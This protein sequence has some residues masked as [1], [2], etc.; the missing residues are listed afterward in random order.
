MKIYGISGL[1]ADKRVFQFLKLDC[2]LIPIDWIMPL[3]N[4]PIENYALRLAKVID[5][6]EEFGI[7]G[8]S[9]GGLIAVELSKKLNPTL[10][11]LISSA[12]TNKELRLIYRLFGKT[13]IVNWIPKEFFNPP[14]FLAHWIFGTRRKKLLNAIL[15]DTDL[16]FAKWAI[17]ELLTWKNVEKIANPCLKI[18]GTKDKLIPP[19]N[20]KNINLIKNGEHFMIADKAVEISQ[21]INNELN[22]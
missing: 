7:L 15:D 4:E 21:I 2:E 22:E 17:Q 18:S 3:K 20:A 9:F 16:V 5:T 11:I 19:N 13:G 1:G 12:E 6:D 14:K 10:T 8:V